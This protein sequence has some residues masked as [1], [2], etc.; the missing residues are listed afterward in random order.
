MFSNESTPKFPCGQLVATP[1]ILRVVS[2]R[3][4]F[5]ALQRHLH[6]DW[7]DLCHA[8]KQSNEQALQNGSRIFSA[9]HSSKGVK[10]WIITE[11][12]RSCTTLLLP[13]EY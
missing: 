12:D 10:F 7:G 3:E 9:Y 8:D 4:L 5:A 6:G 2:H 1:G 11:A 13:S